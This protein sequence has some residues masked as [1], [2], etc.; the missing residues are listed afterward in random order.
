MK[1]GE[2][3]P[4][5]D[6]NGDRGKNTENT[7]PALCSLYI[8]PTKYCNLSCRHCWLA[9]PVK[10][11]LLPE[12]EEMSMG[13]IVDIVK[14]AEKLGLD[15]VKL[16]GGE[17]LLRNDLEELLE[18]C[19]DRYIHT[20]IETNGTLVTKDTAAMFE[21]M[22]VDQVSVSLDSP[23]EE[24]HDR[25]RGKKGAFRQTIEGIKRLR[26]EHYPPQV[27]M[28]LY[29]DNFDH[30]VPFLELMKD[31]GVDNVKINTISYIG[32]GAS[33]KGT[34]AIPTVREILDFS[35][36]LP[37]MTK[38]FKGSVYLDIPAAF[39]SL[40]V[41]QKGGCG[42]CAINNIL[43]ILSDGTVSICGIGYQDEELIFGNVRKDPDALADIWMNTPMLKILREGVPAG[44]KGICGMC[45]LK[46]SCMGSCR[47]EAYFNTGD[48]LAPN[49]F[50]QEAYDGG[51]FPGARVI[52]EELMA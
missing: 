18:Y 24:T 41:A 37:D 16:T 9:P 40:H 39:K 3:M 28:S 21:R 31:I 50:C 20:Y 25:L 29:R 15:T 4:S 30:F 36:R 49:W 13:E 22:A 17:P 14:A 19:L 7:A 27:I 34:N 8:N 43:G 26:D 38:G 51:Y 6:I 48:F 32:R 11:K 35:E 12:D 1:R 42:V 52:P 5:C 33:L 47:A 10:D 44:L 45:V 23:Y 46:R 2:E